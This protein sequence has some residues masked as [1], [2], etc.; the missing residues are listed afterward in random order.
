MK[1]FFLS[2]II[3]FFLLL[4]AGHAAILNAGQVTLEI[5]TTTGVRGGS[6]TA[7]FRIVNRGTEPASQVSALGRFLGIRQQVSIADRINPGQTAQASVRFEIPEPIRGSYPLYV[8]ISYR[9]PN[10]ISAA[11]ASV[12]RV[13]T[14]DQPESPL[15]V[16]AVQGEPPGWG[17]VAVLLDSADRK[18][19]RV[20]VTPHVPGALAVEPP[21]QIVELQQGSGRALFKVINISGSREDTY[22][23]FFTA[24]YEIDGLHNLATAEAAVPAAG[25]LPDLSP[26]AD[27]MKIRFISAILFLA[28]L[29]LITL[30]VS[31]RAREGLLPAD[32]IPLFL[33]VL[34]LAAVEYF[35]FANFDLPSLFSVTT[36][37]GGDTASH[38]YTLE[39]LRHTLLPAGKISG[40]T[41]GNYGGFPILQFYFPLPFLLMSALDL[42]MPLQVAFKL[43][44]VLGTALLPAAAYSLLRL[45]R[46]PFPGPGLGAAL[47]LPFIFNPA[48][49]M[50][51]GN[52]LSTL[53]GEFSYSLSMAL[54]LILIGSLYRGVEENTGV[55]RNGILVFLVGFSHGYTLLFAEAM[56]VFLLLT[57]YGVSR[58]AAYLFRVYALGFCLLAF[59]L[60]P[61]LV[62]TK[63]TTAYHLVWTIHAIGEV[64]PEILLPVVATG[65][66]GSVILL[67]LGG[68]HY[69]NSGRTALLPLAYLWFGL[70]AAVVFFV[71]APR[72]G[73]VDI[74]YVP[75]GQLMAILMAAFFLGWTAKLF[76]NRW[77]LNWIFLI[78][79]VAAVFHWTG[80]RVGP[81]AGWSTWNYEGFEGKAAWPAFQ[82]IN[83]ALAGNFSDPRV[84]FEHSEGHNAFGSSRAF[85]SLPLFAGRATLEGLY[86]QA[87][88]SAPFVFYIQS[89]VSHATSQ[90]FP[91]YNY[92]VMDYNRARRHLELFNV[93]DLVVRSTQAKEAIRQAAGYRLK[94]SIGEYELWELTTNRNRYVEPLRY[95]P[96]LYTGKAPWKQVAHQWFVR[97]E[98]L[99]TPLVFNVAGQP[100]TAPI[101][102]TA[103]SPEAIPKKA[104]DTADC[105][106]EEKINNEEIILETDCV[107]KPHLV[108]VSYHPDWHVE[109]AGKIFLASPSFMLIYPE[110]NRVRLTYGPGPWD[111]LGQFLTV[112]GLLVLLVNVP[113]P[114]KGRGTAWFLLAKRTGLRNL[115]EITLPVGPGSRARKAILALVITGLAAGAAA[116]S[117]NIY[118]SEPFRVYQRSIALKDAK[119]YRKAREGFRLFA[120][121]YPLANL[122]GES[123]YYIAVTYYLEKSDDEAITAF[124]EYIKNFPRGSRVAE[125]HY[126]IGLVLLR[127]GR[128]EAG[129]GKMQMLI[130][131]YPGS[132][133]AGYARERLLEKGITPTGGK[134][135]LNRSNLDQY[136]GRA[137]SAFN[138]D[139]LEEAM[140]ILLE[141]SERF[142]D[143]AGAP[144]ALAA[145]ALCYYKLGDCPSTISNYRKLI[146]RYPGH[147]LAAEAYFHIGDCQ[148]RMG[149]REQAGK[150]FRTVLGIDRNG[151]YGRQA[152]NRLRP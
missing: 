140:P 33:D 57:P 116:A 25:L 103:D 114:I 107:G 61:L 95:E 130:E 5:S 68:L 31:R 147:R 10:G 134:T 139:R 90:P 78:L 125:S 36:T 110:K 104:I 137:I 100:D 44:T 64:V 106:L 88:I 40:W 8:T 143:F 84:V 12:A 120:E 18:V 124:E 41:M 93:R 149:D 142:P 72:I 52:I 89:L 3:P 94:D 46:C 81:V 21:A 74:R 37:T 2:L 144:Q 45:V 86:M 80:A 118:T 65:L 92:A 117:Y 132:P 15:T 4:F 102:L 60:V 83:S 20:T 82:R 146:D 97:D 91:Q 121:Q 75:Y 22:G 152:A 39:Y 32:N 67:I 122:A 115:P 48:N 111:R 51:G 11:G 49:S 16:Q 71:A 113:L 27:T 99:D 141:I 56:S 105:R 59:W 14:G 133:W 47:M 131:K 129:V 112:F 119:D 98:L 69:K 9:H 136:M 87:S 30:I 34:V 70:A 43:V 127:T 1:K 28:A 73:V 128:T 150:A 38:Y 6:V 58:R 123:L 53:A 55:V 135:G 23:L 26:D 145:L 19:D 138:R 35:I 101:T 96:V 63:F 50:W 108:K 24:E 42:I 54:S 66:A 126:H 29:F 85:E 151:V 7:D 62:Y 79:G 109:G 17:T 76:L 77:G 148:E 13:N